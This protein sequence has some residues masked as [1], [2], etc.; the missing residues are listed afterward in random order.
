METP[1]EIL[2]R[3]QAA[4]PSAKL[5]LISN[6]TPANQLS[7]AIRPEDA[8]SIARFLRDDS[9]LRLDYASSVAGVDWLDQV[10]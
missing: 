8:L 1:Q 5:E 2:S 3:L 6:D 7:I 10:T 4:F 9:R